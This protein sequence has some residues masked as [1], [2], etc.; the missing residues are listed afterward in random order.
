MGHLVTHPPATVLTG[1][2]LASSFEE[3]ALSASP[4]PGRGLLGLLPPSLCSEGG[5]FGVSGEPL[6]VSSFS[7]SD[8]HLE[9]MLA[10][11]AIASRSTLCFSVQLRG[12]SGLL[13]FCASGGCLD[14]GD[15]W[16]FNWCETVDYFLVFDQK[17]VVGEPGR[18]A[19]VLSSSVHA[20]PLH[21][22]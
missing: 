2:L 16:I 14:L 17:A 7:S 1:G 22:S 10:L 13:F 6:P 4:R 20:A 21:L 15:I 12:V 18:D 19:H 9:D 8:V 11:A 5:E 3:S